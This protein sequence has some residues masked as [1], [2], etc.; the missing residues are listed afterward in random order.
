ML[1]FLAKNKEVDIGG[2]IRA[3]TLHRKANR[4]KALAL[5]AAVCCWCVDIFR[6]CVEI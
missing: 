4:K 6:G 3:C 1:D 5:R 2:E